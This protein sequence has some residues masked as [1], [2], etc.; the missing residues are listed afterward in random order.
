MHRI[1]TAV[2]VLAAF[3]A[4]AVEITTDTTVSVTAD[5]AESYE[6]ADGA[7]LTFSVAS[8]ATFTL[9]GAITGSGAV[10]KDGAGELVLSNSANSFSGGMYNNAGTLRAT[11]SGA[12]GTGGITN[13]CPASVI[14]DAP[15]GVFPNSIWLTGS[16]VTAGDVSPSNIQFK[17]DTE[18]QGGIDGTV[19]VMVANHILSGAGPTDAKERQLASH[20]DIEPLR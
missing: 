17:K 12:F 18:L 4:G 20:E 14:F 2:F 3:A 5:S 9:S 6:I 8:G 19:N 13:K 15:N 1:L 7:T 10:R 16:D 11:A